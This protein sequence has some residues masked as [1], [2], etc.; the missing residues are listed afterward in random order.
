MPSCTWSRRPAAGSWSSS[1][2][3]ETARFT[4][5]TNGASTARILG[6]TIHVLGSGGTGIADCSTTPNTTVTAMQ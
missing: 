1:A 2:A 4:K 6:R 3:P 5:Y